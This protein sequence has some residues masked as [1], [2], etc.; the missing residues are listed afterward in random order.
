MNKTLKLLCTTWLALTAMSVFAQKYGGP[1]PLSFNIVS[2]KASQG[3]TSAEVSV[4][5]PTTGGETFLRSFRSLLHKRLAEL[6]RATQEEDAPEKPAF[7][8]DLA[9]TPNTAVCFFTDEAMKY[10][11]RNFSDEENADE[12]EVVVFDPEECTPCTF[13][14]SCDKLFANYHFASFSHTGDIYLGGA[15]GVPITDIYTIA[16][17]DGKL[18]TMED[19][20]PAST[21][22]KLKA[23]VYRN[24]LKEYD[25]DNFWEDAATKLPGDLGVALVRE[26]VRFQYDAY[27]IGPYV[28]GTPSVTIPYSELTAIMSAKAKRWI[29]N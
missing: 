19:I 2:A 13:E 7:T 6:M 10:Q 8:S 15:H 24:L 26:G 25:E 4:E 22:R 17:E 27:E 16:R 18:V 3:T 5:Y 28:I 12:N 20:F 14:F 23:I 29:R 1:Q 9:A 21:H 11:R